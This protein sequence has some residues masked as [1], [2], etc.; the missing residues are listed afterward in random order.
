MAVMIEPKT[1]KPAV[2]AVEA[3]KMIGCDPSLIRHWARQGHLRKITDS[4]RKIYYLVEE[5]KRRG[6]DAE[7]TK[8]KRGGRPRKGHAA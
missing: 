4:P 7:A 1:G 3:A 6:K 2:S 5:I 8:K